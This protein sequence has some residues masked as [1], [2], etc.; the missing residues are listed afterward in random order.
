M[1]TGDWRVPALVAALLIG[2]LLAWGAARTPR[3]LPTDAPDTVFS[4]GRAMVDDRAMAAH[5]HPIGSAE[6]GL[7]R[8]YLLQRMAALG[9]QPRT[10]TGEAVEIPRWAKGDFAVGARVENLIGVLKGTDPALPAVV[11]MAHSD[12]VPGSPGAADDAAGVASALEVVRALKAAGTHRRDVAVLITDGEEAGLL[13]ARAFFGSDDPLLP[14]IGEVVNLEARG[15]GGRVN[16]FQTG[17]RDGGHLAVFRRAVGDS[18]ANSLTSEVYK[19]MPNDTDFTVSRNKGLPGFN[20]AFVGSEFDYH[21]PS[22]TPAALDQGALQHMGD[23]ALA[24]VRALADAPTLPKPGA[25]A[26]YSDL[27]GR[28]VIAY[29][30]ALGGWLILLVSAGLAGIAAWRG[31]RLDGARPLRPG[32]MAWGA[33][34]TLLTTVVLGLALWAAGQCVGLGDFARHRAL[35]ADYPAFFAGF[36]LLAVGIGLVLV[37]PVQPGKSWTVLVGVPETR[38]SGWAGS[39]LVLALLSLFLQLRFTPMAMLTEWP[40]LA[41]AV[42]MAATAWLGGR[43]EARAA[44]VFAGVVGLIAVAHLGHFADQTFTAVGEMAPELLALFVLIAV[45]VLFPLLAGWGRAGWRAQVAGLAV[46]VLG[47]GVLV[48]AGV[49]SPWSARTPRA[50]QAFFV[51][52]SAAGRSWKASALDT[53]DPWSASALG[54]PASKPIRQRTPALNADLWLTPAA[55]ASEPTPV[56]TS[57]RDGAAVVVHLTP[58]AGGR[59]LRLALTSTVAAH[60]VSLDG[61]PA[62]ILGKAGVVSYVRWSAA[63]EGLTLRF[64]PSGPGELDLKYAEIKD[65]WPAGMAPSPK[66]VGV[67]PW[68]LSDTTVVLAELKTRW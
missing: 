56:F 24:I 20:F 34:G 42:T 52:D 67:M 47:A 39:F 6:A 36:A 58:Q 25:D 11:L 31:Q 37:G 48:Y 14:H 60:D 3:P 62:A 53:L 22:S 13:G 61:K 17:E 15:G 2:A 23:Q 26:A 45:P 41:A 40:L 50:V 9:M 4:A 27:L 21:S 8:S 1:K 32:A 19:Y 54:A 49:H 18:N 33:F 55:K 10:A 46:A 30:A 28:G 64:V 12:S 51:Q 38:W 35:L 5:P 59:E 16:M 44:A 57:S 7:V 43:F 63:G 68:G 65:G 66:P 29:P